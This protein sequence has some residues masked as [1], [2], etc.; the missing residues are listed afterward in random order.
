MDFKMPLGHMSSEEADHLQ[1]IT[2]AVKYA[3]LYWQR[4]GAGTL[5]D[6][7]QVSFLN[8]RFFICE[9]QILISVPGDK[10]ACGY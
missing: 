1:L 3:A 5:C 2:T 8:L 4:L 9:I 7:G 6:L 10:G